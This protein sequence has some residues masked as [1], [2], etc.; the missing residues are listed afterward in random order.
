MRDKLHALIDRLRRLVLR[1]PVSDPVSGFLML[2]RTTL[3]AGVRHVSAFGFKI[4]LDLLA[5]L[6]APPRLIE[7]PYGFRSRE[8]GESKLDAGVLR[9]Y[10]LLLADKSASRSFAAS[11]RRRMPMSRSSCSAR[12]IPGG[13][14]VRP[15][16]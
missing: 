13:L 3:E 8:A 14:P 10:A 4:L 16:R 9:D 5:S 11:A 7:L 1:T 15:G 12:T 2:R 6:P